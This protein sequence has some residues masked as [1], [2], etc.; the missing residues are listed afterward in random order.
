[1]KIKR[2]DNNQAVMVIVE[3]VNQARELFPSFPECPYRGLAVI[4]EEFGEL[5]QAALQHDY[6]GGDRKAIRKEA[7]QLGAVVIRFL[8]MLPP[9]ATND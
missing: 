8:T 3:E 5:Q 7:V 1:M 6:E 2:W 4:G 9:E